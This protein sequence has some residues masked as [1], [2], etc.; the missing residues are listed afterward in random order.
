MNFGKWLGLAATTAAVAL[1]WSL[2][3]V[4]I[5]AFAAVVLAMAICTLVGFVQQRLRC[6]RSLALLVSV[7]G[8]VV[9]LAVAIAV[10]IPPFADQFGL[11]LTKVPTAA[12]LL[13]KMGRESLSWGGKMI[14]GQ[15]ET[16]STSTG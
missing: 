3:G 13:L 14:Y 9:V 4:V 2:R 5:Q 8:L 7:L 16:P 1:L 11:L 10:L 6:N 15:Q 12:A